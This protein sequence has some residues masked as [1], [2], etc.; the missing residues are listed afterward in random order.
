[1][2]T[3][4]TA[5]GNFFWLA[6]ALHKQG[7]WCG[8][9]KNATLAKTVLCACL[10]GG[11]ALYLEAMFWQGPSW[12]LFSSQEIPLFIRSLP[13]QLVQFMTLALAFGATFLA[14]AYAMGLKDVLCLLGVRKK[15]E[16]AVQ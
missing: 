1:M 5:F 4:L 16:D 2:A 12:L 8:V 3:S 15:T 13:G 9:G 10:A 11:A 7:H 14:L 6:Y